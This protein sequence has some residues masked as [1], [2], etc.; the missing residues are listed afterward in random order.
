MK[1][2]FTRSDPEPPSNNHHEWSPELQENLKADKQTFEN[3]Q[4]A[5]G[6]AEEAAEQGDMKS[7]QATRR[8]L[9]D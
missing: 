2:K 9:G 6:N 1:F 8:A 7:A 4:Q 3:H 5:L